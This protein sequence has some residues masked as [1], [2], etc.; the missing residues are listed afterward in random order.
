MAKKETLG[1]MGKIN[2]KKVLITGNEGYIGC[3]LTEY[4]I[5]AGFEVTGLDNGVFKNA[6]FVFPKFKAKHQI[7][8]DIR[9]VKEND[10]KGHDS[11]VHLAALSNDSLGY[12]NP[13]LT[14]E[15][16]WKASVKLAE[17]SKRI[18]IKRFIFISSCSVYGISEGEI[19][20]ETSSLA[21]QTPY[22]ESKIKAEMDISSFGDSNFAPVFLRAATVFGVSPRL[23]LD[24]VVNDLLAQAC[25][26]K[27]MII[28]SDGTPWRPVLY[29]RDLC[30]AIH[31]LLEAPKE[32]VANQVFNIGDRNNNLQIRDIAL[33]IKKMLSDVE[34]EIKGMKVEDQ[35]SYQVSFDKIY[36]LGW[37]PKY[38]FREG[39][40]ETEK[41]FRERLKVNSLEDINYITLK[42]YKK[43]LGNGRLDDNLRMIKV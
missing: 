13:L 34:I 33:I 35:R 42:K 40:Q 15:I 16:N 22:A 38:T 36:S 4:L 37:R 30:E 20:N 9:D 27:K 14:Y 3:V 10:L 32:K 41:V 26:F 6:R 5:E 21:P 12:L 28:L 39:L 19:A 7:Y 2:D 8:K 24:L 29:I 43:L 31:F 23:R 17:L 11:V 25:L 18:G 1:S